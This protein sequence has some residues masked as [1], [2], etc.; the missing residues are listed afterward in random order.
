M[1]GNLLRRYFYAL[2][3][4]NNTWFYTFVVFAIISLVMTVVLGGFGP[5]YQSKIDVGQESEAS[6]MRHNMARGFGAKTNDQLTG[7]QLRSL[8]HGRSDLIMVRHWIARKIFL[9]A[10][11][12]WSVLALISIPIV[13]RD[14]VGDLIRR[15][16]QR[17]N[18]NAEET[19]EEQ[20]AR[21]ASNSGATG[22]MAVSVQTPPTI[23]PIAPQPA[24][25][26][27]N[28]GQPQSLSGRF[29]MELIAEWLAEV[30][31]RSRKK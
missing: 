26:P 18:A 9:R 11:I 22:G 8:P 3:T 4:N 19:D 20:K 17:L 14:E 30:V 16:R 13:F 24:A 5:I 27:V 7:G 15:F 12:F 29:I 25:Q 31:F 10:C 2:R 1:I 6:Q 28:Q 23:P 21:N